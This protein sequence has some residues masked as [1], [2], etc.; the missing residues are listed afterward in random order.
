MVRGITWLELIAVLFSKKDMH[1]K[2]ID[3][4]LV[5]RSNSKRPVALK[6]ASKEGE[7]T[8]PEVL[9]GLDYTEAADIWSFGCIMFEIATKRTLFP[10]YSALFEYMQP[11]AKERVENELKLVAPFDSIVWI[12]LNLDPQG[13][14]T[15]K[16][17]LEELNERSEIRTA[18]MNL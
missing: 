10:S 17:I 2:L 16:W 1:W 3:Y 14:P 9:D 15:C 7:Y 13:R 8:A 4:G 5:P 11:A 12:A 18:K 6:H